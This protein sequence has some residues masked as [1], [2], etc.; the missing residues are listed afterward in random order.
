ME[1]QRV[2]QALKIVGIV[3]LVAFFASFYC[4][5]YM[6]VASNISN[7]PVGI[8][9]KD[10]GATVDGKTVNVGNSI[11]EALKDDNKANWQFLDDTAMDEGI[12]KTGYILI[13]E[14]PKDFS[15]N[16][17]AG[18]IGT[19][20]AADLVVYR[21]VRYNYIFSQ[22]SSQIVKAF[23][24]ALSDQVVKAYVSGAYNG[25]YSARDGMS[26]AAD[27]AG[28]LNE[29]ITELG[30]GLS[31][32]SNAANQATDGA[33]RLADGSQALSSGTQDLHKGAQ[34]LAQGNQN[35]ADGAQKLSSGSS[36]LASGMGQLA[37]STQSLPEQTKKMAE[38]LDGAHAK[39][40]EATS[41][42]AQLEKASQTIT[43]HLDKL[44]GEMQNGGKS[45]HELSQKLEA[46]AHGAQ[47][48]KSG[49]ESLDKLYQ[50]AFA[51]A[52]SGGS[53]NGKT[54][55]E[56]LELAKQTS[57][58]INEGATQ[59]STQLND[60]AQ[61]SGAAA[62]NLSTTVKLVGNSKTQDKSLAYASR[63]V[64][65]GL[66]QLNQE[67]TGSTDGM[68]TLAGYAHQLASGSQKLADSTLKLDSA[69]HELSAGAANLAGGA[70]RA[71]SGA[72]DLNAGA[73][74][75]EQGAGSLST[76]A[77]KL[78]EGMP[79][80]Q[81]G[82]SSASEGTGELSKGASTLDGSLA[83]GAQSINKA[84]GASSEEMGEFAA[85]P[86]QT[87]QESFGALDVYG[88]GFA[89]F[90]MTTALWL[91]ALL[92]FFVVDPMYPKRKNA[93]RVRT[94][95]GRLPIYLLVCALESAGVVIAS[96]AIGVTDAYEVN[97][98]LL[99]LFAFIVSSSFMLIMQFLSLTFGV[100]GRGIAVALLIIQLSA[101]G[102]TLPVELGHPELAVI[103]P[104]LPYTYS[105]D[106]FREAIS[107]GRATVMGQDA[108][109]LLS[110]GLIFLVL[111][112]LCWRL[113][114]MRQEND[115]AEYIA[116][117]L[118][119]GY[120]PQHSA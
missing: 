94:V 113:A 30:S 9:N 44:S 100:V 114:L 85:N 93:G 110:I 105:I 37:T 51:A 95:I 25:L 58:Q 10:E 59:L 111:S 75:L 77:N 38:S 97:Y 7:V 60:A 96:I 20:K 71:A 98:L 90:F 2:K 32:A 33:K 119:D 29:G 23:E 14:I 66:S 84:L 112:L 69:S 34:D 70:S 116:Y 57:Q 92:I 41:A 15:K 19:P 81:S 42:T 63:Q 89:P 11:V 4:W 47:Q 78:A 108:L 99:Y 6:D 107:L 118:D 13:F 109:I 35:L 18:E 26:E 65:D 45:L 68:G 46:G 54:S 22:F 56:W 104:L 79:K 88:Q 73:S 82:L 39:M 86:V 83:D 101:A 67:F 28:K 61:A 87:K 1:A 40:S 27:G 74:K 72:K 53:F 106:G 91:G 31:K 3:L 120:A 76:N 21:N 52:Q 102:G 49:T 64:S 12:E 117:H 16:A 17:S 115:N 80:L 36:E 43:T 24:D 8:I 5:S 103:K 55:E 62:D 48:L 50:A